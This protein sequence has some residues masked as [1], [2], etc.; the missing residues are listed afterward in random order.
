M[1]LMQRFSQAVKDKI[2]EWSNPWNT[3]F[4]YYGGTHKT[5]DSPLYRH[6]RIKITKND[7]LIHIATSPVFVHYVSTPAVRPV[8]AVFHVPGPATT[9]LSTT[10]EKEAIEWLDNFFEGAAMSLSEKTSFS[11]WKATVTA[12]PRPETIPH[13]VWPY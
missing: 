5:E 4:D 9:C 8:S 1:S 3:S 7:S 11:N 6:D 2:N 12:K 13:P 10:S